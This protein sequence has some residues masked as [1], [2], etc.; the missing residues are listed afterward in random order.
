MSSNGALIGLVTLSLGA[1]A[2]VAFSMSTATEERADLRSV[3]ES[4]AADD[5]T[6]QAIAGLR[7][8]ITQLGEQLDRR[9]AAIEQ[10]LATREALSIGGA[11]GI[12]SAS[13]MEENTEALAARVA[14][15]VQ[16]QMEA[17]LERLASRQRNRNMGGEWKAPIDEL[18]VELDLTDAQS[19][20]ATAIFDDARDDVYALLTTERSDGG[21]LL[22]D[23]ATKIRSG[24]Q[25]ALPKF[26]G[27][28]FSDH[29]PNS[30][31]TYLARMIALSEEVRSNL[32]PHLS[33]AQMKRMRDLNVAVLEV[34]TGYDP[35][36]DYIRSKTP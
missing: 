7:S 16:G 9:L 30:D 11:G 29:V 20:T 22:D 15:S 13:A 35:V 21:N 3:S 10:Q 14:E 28:I 6:A 17:Q 12:G 18:A 34:E 36:G 8:E 24:E 27:R 31:Q 19:E 26:I 2:Y 25:D 5:G 23:L 4:P 32:S 33:E 1:T